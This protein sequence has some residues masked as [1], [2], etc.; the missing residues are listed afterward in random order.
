M[1]T[2]L[3]Y[4]EEDVLELLDFV[5]VHIPSKLLEEKNEKDRS[6]GTVILDI[7][8]WIKKLRMAIELNRKM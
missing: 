8:T 2:I 5:K 4:L 7:K 3:D 1:E 6:I